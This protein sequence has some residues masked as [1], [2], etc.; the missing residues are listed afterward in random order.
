MKAREEEMSL[1]SAS[2]LRRWL[3]RCLPEPGMGEREK[4]PPLYKWIH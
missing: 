2:F 3:A 1:S 4:D